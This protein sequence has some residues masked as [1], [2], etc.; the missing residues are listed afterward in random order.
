MYLICIVNKY[1]DTLTTYYTPTPHKD[2]IADNETLNELIDLYDYANRGWIKYS[3][4]N[5]LHDGNHYLQST[6]REFC[7]L[8]L[9]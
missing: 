2:Y 9:I 1:G 6:I 4:K 3:H 8:S 5:W 7:P